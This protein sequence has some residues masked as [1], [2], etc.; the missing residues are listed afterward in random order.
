MAMKIVTNFRVLMAKAHAVGQAKLHGTPEELEK[1]QK[2]HDEYKELCLLSD[3]MT[4]DCSL[5]DLYGKS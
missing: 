4:L 1:A 2:E 3:E 5:S